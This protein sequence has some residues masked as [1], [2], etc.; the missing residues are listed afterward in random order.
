MDCSVQK[1]RHPGILLVSTTDFFFP[2]VDD[3]Y[4][5]GRIGCANVLSDM[6][7]MGVQDCDSVLMLIAASTDMTPPERN[8][9][10][11]LM[12]K[13]FND[14][15]TEAGT[16][17]TGGQTVLNPWPI[18]G[19]VAEAVVTETEL[20]IPEHAV[21]GDVIVLTKP[22]GTQPAVNVMQWMNKNEPLWAK[23]KDVITPEEVSAAYLAAMNSMARLN[24]TGAGLMHKHGVRAATDVT[25]FGILGHADNLAKNQRAE[26]TLRLHTL[27]VI[28][29]MDKVNEIFDFKLLA[30]R[31]A[32]TSGG[33]MVCLP[34]AAAEAFI[35]DIVAADGCPAWIIGDVVAGPRQ[36]ELVESPRILSV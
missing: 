15:C 30:G 13:G 11:E 4:L 24:R 34:A 32:E 1:S 31:S 20:I 14:L 10:T 23:A 33:L 7:A 5:Q 18:I 21:A 6:Y 3:P 19:G 25:G 8:I 12:M 22:L 28:N 26:V 29:K 17:V 35:A 9:V 16:K 27:P 36:G 2:L